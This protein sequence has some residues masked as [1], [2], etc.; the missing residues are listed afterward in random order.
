LARLYGVETRVLNQAVKRN[1]KRFP[2]D[3]MFRL[4]KV[5]IRKLTSQIVI[6]S[7]EN[8]D[9]KPVMSEHGGSRHLSF[10][11]T[12]SGIAMLSSVLKSEIAI[13]VNIQIMRAF[14]AMRNTLFNYTHLYNRIEV[15]ES[16]QLNLIAWKNR[17][18]GKFVEIFNSISKYELPK[19]D[20][21]FDG[22]LFD[23]H[24]LMSQLVESAEKRI[25]L[26]D[27]YIDASV[28]TL[29]LKRKKHVPAT[30]YTMHT[31]RFCYSPCDTL[32]ILT[33]LS[34]WQQI[35]GGCSKFLLSPFSI[36]LYIYYL[37]P[38]KPF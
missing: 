1:I 14:T 26:I 4:T 15:I 25:V 7:L 19:Q 37:C 2:D 22:Q 30:V 23:A 35:E 32:L 6:S 31:Q 38:I 5:E 17:A 11:F 13:N 24:I 29:L 34:I 12:E 16:T 36:L 20:V 27:N 8:T 21:F 18:E 3:F 28:L 9:N 10:A 33:S